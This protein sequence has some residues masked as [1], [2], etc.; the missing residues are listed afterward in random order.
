MGV[1]IN[2]YFLRFAKLASA[3]CLNFSGGSGQSYAKCWS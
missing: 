3:A 1:G 2:D